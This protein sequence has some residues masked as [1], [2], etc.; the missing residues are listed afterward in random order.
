[1]L[2]QVLQRKRTNDLAVYAE[3]NLVVA[4]SKDDE[5]ERGLHVELPGGA[6][7][8]VQLLDGVG[9]AAD[10]SWTVRFGNKVVWAK[11]DE[12]LH[13]IIPICQ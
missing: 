11:H 1:M 9:G 12:K 13:I 6:V 7:D 10:I 5:I 2:H 4:H 8:A 3:Q